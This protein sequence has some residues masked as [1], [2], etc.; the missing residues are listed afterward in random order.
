MRGAD[1][2]EPD[3]LPKRRDPSPSAEAHHLHS[4][5]RLSAPGSTESKTDTPSNT[6]DI[7]HH[8]VTSLSP[9]YNPGSIVIAEIYFNVTQTRRL[10]AIIVAFHWGQ[11]E[12]SLGD[13]RKRLP[14]ITPVNSS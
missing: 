13:V 14:I 9:N 5:L 4:S 3:W 12:V 8:W 6:Q 7:F 1:G 2:R 11:G 10:R